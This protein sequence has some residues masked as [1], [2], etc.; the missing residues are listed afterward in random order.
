MSYF[1]ETHDSILKMPRYTA[2][3]LIKWKIKVKEEE[4]QQMDEHL[5]SAR[6]KR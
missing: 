3:R 5:E 4:K 2:D 6:S 1:H